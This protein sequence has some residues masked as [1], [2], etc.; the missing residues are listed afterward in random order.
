[1]ARFF[2]D[3]TLVFGAGCLGGL[4]NSLLVWICGDTGITVAAGVRIAPALTVAWL[5]PRIVWGGLW[6]ALFLL[7]VRR[8]RLWLSGLVFS[9]G[10]S[11][12]QLFYIFPS[13]AGKGLMGFDLG[14]LTPVFV[15]VFNAAWGLSAAFWLQVIKR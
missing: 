5:Y 10:P 3:M 8:N 4:V 1:M 13:V 7:P 9:L 12:V 15:L 14:L 6:G 11:A 2:R